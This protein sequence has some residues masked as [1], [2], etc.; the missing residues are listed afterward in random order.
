MVVS[1]VS[2]LRSSLF[3]ARRLSPLHRSFLSTCSKK[4][5]VDDRSVWCLEIDNTDEMETLGASLA[6][7]TSAGDVICLE[8]DLGAGK[9]ALSR[10]FVR[11][12]TGIPRLRVTSPSYLLDQ[13]YVVED[14]EDEDSGVEIHHMDLYRV[15]KEANLEALGFPDILSEAIVLLEWPDRLGSLMPPDRLEIDIRIGARDIR[16]VQLT[17]HGSAWQTR[18]A[19]CVAERSR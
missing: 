8:G 15:S 13:T 7:G 2:S 11:S 1:S 5:V 16:S 12:R 17:A 9:T 6:R 10:G 3:N 18:V 19:A 4:T 14:E